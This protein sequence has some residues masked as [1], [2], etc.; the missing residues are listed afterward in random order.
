MIAGTVYIAV[1]GTE[2]VRLSLAFVAL[3][4]LPLFAYGGIV[5]WVGALLTGTVVAGALYSRVSS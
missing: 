1:E 4:A 2:V 5:Q 3:A